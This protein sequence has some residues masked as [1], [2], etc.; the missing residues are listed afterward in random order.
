MR[1]EDF[2]RLYR[3][4]VPDPLPAGMLERIRSAQ[5]RDGAEETS[6]PLP[7][8]DAREDVRLFFDLLRYCWSGYPYYAE[9]FDFSALRD[10]IM[11]ALPDPVPAAHLRELLCASLKPFV[12]DSHFSFRG[13]GRLDKPIRA[14]FTA[15]TVRKAEKG[16]E[17]VRSKREDIP[18]GW[19]LTSENVRDRL[20]ETLPSP[21]GTRLYLVGTLAESDPGTMDLCG[22]SVPLHPCRTDGFEV[23]GGAWSE[24][25]DG[26]VKISADVSF[27]GGWV[28]ETNR[29]LGK[30]GDVHFERGLS[31][32]SDPVLVWSLLGN[33]G[34]DSGYPKHFVEGLNGYAVWESECAERKLA[35]T[36]P[37]GFE[38]R[39]ETFGSPRVDLSRSEYDGRLFVLQNKQTASSGEAAVMYARSVKN[40]VFVGSATMG[41]GQFGDLMKWTLPHSGVTFAMGYKVF[42]MEGF[43]EGRG[44]LP[45]LWLD[46]DRPWDELCAWIRACG[47]N[48]KSE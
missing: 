36:D 42:H 15:I 12:S 21:D 14:Y 24:W 4:R 39:C 19:F 38:V 28:A 1:Q 23:P 3:N 46:S 5:Y 45:D 32:R 30:S 27:D 35:Q 33:H 22:R 41:C 40:A 16:Y 26:G 29:S 8:E 47:L 10:R 34:G 25:E 18:A 13:G 31:H 7:V 37:S 9:R 11:G 20:F 17:V 2:D 44:L 48:R 6:D 43:E